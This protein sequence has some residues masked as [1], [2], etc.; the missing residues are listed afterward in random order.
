MAVTVAI[1]TTASAQK[2]IIGERAPEVKV[3]EW[4]NGTPNNN[5]PM[6]IEFYHSSSKQ[7]QDR[8]PALN[9]LAEKYTGKLSVVV[10]AREAKD[11]VMSLGLDRNSKFYPAIDDNSKTFT[12]Y[13]V[14]FV[15]FGAVV[16]GKGRLAWFGN[17]SSLSDSELQGYIK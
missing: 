8:I 4:I 16:D 2:L 15:P 10:I 1:A 6:L 5:K 12:N 11:K 17:P 14:Q 13:G 7:S 3:S 9:K